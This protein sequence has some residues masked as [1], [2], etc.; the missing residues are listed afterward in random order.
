MTSNGRAA[1]S[2]RPP[3]NPHTKHPR[4]R[5]LRWPLWILAP[6]AAVYVFL[7]VVLDWESHLPR[8]PR[9]GI[10]SGVYQSLE[11][12][13]SLN[14]YGLFR[15]M[16]RE[17]PEIVIEGS[18]DHEHW[19]AYAFRY[20]PG[21]LAAAP[22]FIAPHMPRL[23]W[24]MWFAALGS[25]QN[26]PWFMQLMARLLEGS[27]PV[28]QLLAKNPFPDQPPKYVRAVLY[29]YHF[30]DP[31]TRRRTGQWWQRELRG[32]YCPEFSLRN[33]DDP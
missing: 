15:V 16:T 29:D 13:H 20:K 22:R 32:A 8:M 7:S 24:Q 18:N 9:F 11:P 1:L 10:L 19:E 33:R 4:E 3:V 28:T 30:T 17:R 26:N 25:Y 6:V 27:A 14:S 12:F 23:D 21:D 31:A 5:G 2:H